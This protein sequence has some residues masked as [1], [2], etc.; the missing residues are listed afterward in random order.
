MKSYSYRPQVPFPR[1]LGRAYLEVLLFC[2]T[3]TCSVYTA[4]EKLIA[5][6][7]YTMDPQ[8]SPF[9]YPLLLQ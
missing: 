1:V 6:Y 8:T 7:K 9:L 4:V 2:V 5:V 3:L